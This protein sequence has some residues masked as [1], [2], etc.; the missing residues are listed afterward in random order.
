MA[1][2]KAKL[3]HF[4]SRMYDAS[5]GQESKQPQVQP[6]DS[7][8][9][10]M[11]QLE[12]KKDIIQ[13]K[14]FFRDLSLKFYSQKNQ[15]SLNQNQKNGKS[16]AMKKA[17]KK[18]GKRR[19]SFQ[20]KK[21]LHLKKGAPKKIIKGGKTSKKQKKTIE[22]VNMWRNKQNILKLMVIKKKL[23]QGK[24]TNQSLRQS[25][26]LH[27][28]QKST[29]K[30]PRGDRTKNRGFKS[31]RAKKQSSKDSYQQ[32]HHHINNTNKFYQNHPLENLNVNLYFST[33]QGPLPSKGLN[34]YQTAEF[35]E[36]SQQ[37]QS[38]KALFYLPNSFKFRP[39]T[40]RKSKG[41]SN[42]SAHQ[43]SQKNDQ[44]KRLILG[45]REELSLNKGSRSRREISKKSQAS[46]KKTSKHYMKNRGHLNK[47]Q[48]VEKVKRKKL[49]VSNKGCYVS[50]YLGDDHIK[51][52]KHYGIRPKNAH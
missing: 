38:S 21:G 17:L 6:E 26:T 40:S 32:I 5:E 49:S 15:E 45:R 41:Y 12:I 36:Q 34:T 4:L 22:M 50:N 9:L 42:S 7:G 3:N 8:T 20:Q 27:K 28:S 1:T 47:K 24:P 19:D 25:K 31:S 44:K 13:D 48:S 35:G 46:V 37:Y 52:R 43:N 39:T 11:S 23:M 29:Q 33:H 14:G 2:S 18:I 30:T 51:A 16:M 10:Q